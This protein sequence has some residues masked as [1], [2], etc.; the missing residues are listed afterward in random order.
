MLSKILE[1]WNG[2]YDDKKPQIVKF[3][4]QNIKSL[5]LRRHELS[6]ILE[7]YASNKLCVGI[8]M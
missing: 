6:Y 3:N 4:V 8:L 7:T 2:P 5:V 1:A